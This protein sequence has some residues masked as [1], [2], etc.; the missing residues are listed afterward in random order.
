MKSNAKPVWLGIFFYFVLSVV[1]ETSA[2]AQAPPPATPMLRIEAAMHT[3]LITSIDVDAGERYL[4]S[5]S[6]DKTS[7]VWD[8]ASG[9]L[10]RTLRF[11]INEGNDG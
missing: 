3:A 4:V 11:P 5:G 2:P 1:C 9:R 8:L 7:R 6:V 10:L